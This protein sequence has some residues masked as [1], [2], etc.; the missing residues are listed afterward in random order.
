MKQL[1]LTFQE[2]LT[3]GIADY[4]LEF[5]SKTNK[6]IETIESEKIIIKES[7]I[8]KFENKKNKYKKPYIKN[9]KKKYYKKYKKK[10]K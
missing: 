4:K 1:K 9:T 5:K 6:L 10:T 7:N 8:I 3:F 2:D